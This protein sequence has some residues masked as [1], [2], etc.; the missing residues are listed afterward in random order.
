MKLSSLFGNYKK[1][2]GVFQPKEQRTFY[3]LISISF[4]SVILEIVGL[5]II[6]L[7]IILVLDRD[8]GLSK[9]ETF[10]QYN[11]L[12]YT[13]AVIS[14]LITFIMKSITAVLVHKWQLKKL[15]N[16]SGN[17]AARV[18]DQS[19]E[20]GL[21]EHKNV[22][23]TERLNNVTTIGNGFPMVVLLPAITVITELGILVFAV[24]VLILL[25][26]VL[27]LVLILGLLPQT[28]VILFLSKRKL[29]SVGKDVT[30][31][32]AIQNEVIANSVH[33]YAEINL[34]NLSDLYKQQYRDIQN[35]IYKDRM[36]IQV[37][38]AALPA[39]LLEALTI[40]GLCI[41]SV[42]L[43]QSN[44]YEALLGT[45]ALFAATAFRV[46]PSLNR[47]VGSANSFNAYIDITESIP[48]V[49]IDK[50]PTNSIDIEQ[51]Q[52]LEIKNLHFAFT[53]QFPIFKN[54]NLLVTKGDYVGIYGPS[55]TGKTTLINLI[56]GLY[57]SKQ[58]SVL[59][60]EYPINE[61]QNS[62]QSMLGYVKQDAFMLSK[63]VIENIAFGDENP[64]ETRVLELLKQVNLLSWVQ[65]LP[66]G[67][68][69]SIGDHGSLIS[70]GQK[71]RIAIARALYRNASVLIFDEVTNSL[72][73]VNKRDIW[74]IIRDLHALGTTIIMISHD[75]DAF[76][77]ANKVYKIVNGNLEAK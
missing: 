32:Y 14:L 5:A 30:D 57:K 29:D 41:L 45:L 33:G 8:S 68:Q 40:G 39:R 35:D 46:L 43:Y 76:E 3:Q 63:S 52:K 44:D 53:N 20:F 48:K 11:N 60:N 67:V 38:G 50:K 17:L 47:I 25:K 42:Y 69:T 71:Q 22:S 26:P 58:G 6:Y 37:F 1:L 75:L 54:T 66:N 34:F 13:Y 51:F 31:K 73:D 55:G 15:F 24:V 77:Y 7:L 36:K 18:F 62:W 61:V 23:M 74:S 21:E 59:I 4:L 27:V 28:A 64:E 19:F 56:L 10:L 16:I 2:F 70:G 12:S 72:D 49:P 65:D 9:I